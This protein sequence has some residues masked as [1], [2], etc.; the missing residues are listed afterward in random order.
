MLLPCW[1]ECGLEMIQ[2]G[3]DTKLLKQKKKTF[4]SLFQSTL[5][6]GSIAIS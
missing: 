4:L 5:N 2:E 3:P 1:E 6:Y